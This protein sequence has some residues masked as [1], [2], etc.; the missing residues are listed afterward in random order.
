[1]LVGLVWAGQAR[2]WLPGFDVLDARRSTTLVTFAPLAAV[3]GAHFVSLQIGPGGGA[4]E[5]A[6]TRALS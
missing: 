5:D 2:P 1:M 3:R 4:G 6:A